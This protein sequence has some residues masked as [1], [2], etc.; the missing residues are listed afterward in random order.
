MTSQVT[1]HDQVSMVVMFNCDS[2]SYLSDLFTKLC[3]N[4]FQ[5]KIS[6]LPNL[7]S[8]D[9]S[10]YSLSTKMCSNLTTAMHVWVT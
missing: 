2:F 10:E 4:F 8:S 1:N 5:R 7:I 9:K 3:L 6:Q